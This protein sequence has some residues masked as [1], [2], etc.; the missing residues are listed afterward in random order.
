MTPLFVVF[1]NLRA[2]GP[3]W[4]L[5]PVECWEHGRWW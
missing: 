1:Y 5:I 4:Q 2:L 3:A